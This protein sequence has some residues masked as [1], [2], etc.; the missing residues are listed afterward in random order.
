MQRDG[1]NWGFA[2][3]ALLVLAGLYVLMWRH[4]NSEPPPA[5]PAYYPTTPHAPIDP[6][7]NVSP[8]SLHSD[9]AAYT[10]SHDEQRVYFVR[11][12]GVVIA[13]HEYIVA[14]KTER[15]LASFPIPKGFTVDKITISKDGQVAALLTPHTTPQP[16]PPRTVVIPPRGRAKTF[17]HH[18]AK[19]RTV[20]AIA[21]SGAAIAWHYEHIAHIKKHSTPQIDF[22]KIPTSPAWFDLPIRQPVP[23]IPTVPS[24]RFR[25]SEPYTADAYAEP[26]QPH[27]THEHPSNHRSYRPVI[28][29]TPP[30]HYRPKIDIDIRD[31]SP[32][33][34]QHYD[35]NTIVLTEQHLCCSIRGRMRKEITDWV[36]DTQIIG[37]SDSGNIVIGNY[38]HDLQWCGFIWRVGGDVTTLHYP[39]SQSTQLCWLSPQGDTVLGLAALS[40]TRTVL[41]RWSRRGGYKR[42]GEI[43]ENIEEVSIACI[44]PNG[45][46]VLINLSSY[47]STRGYYVWSEQLGFR[48]SEQLRYVLTKPMSI[49]NSGR[50][51]LAETPLG[52]ALVKVE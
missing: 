27:E 29:S 13:S 52:V 2:G 22:H 30:T 37:V 11:H 42:L 12:N 24:H 16:T 34:F 50:R 26:T 6:Y 20:E 3:V 46:A 31:V 25:D 21:K 48:K 39:D 9:A 8:I 45:Q 51:I 32:P 17:T 4:N 5:T 18:A 41:F 47:A 35:P 14:T 38:F 1:F 40:D 33:D 49:S 23:Q 43:P 36:G 10:F 19:G 7:R 15:P 44:A 28:R